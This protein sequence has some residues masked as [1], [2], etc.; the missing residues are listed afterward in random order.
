MRNL[1]GLTPILAACLALTTK[2]AA[3]QSQYGERYTE[4][5]EQSEPIVVTGIRIQDYRDRLRNCLARNCPPNEDIDATLALAEA[6][7]LSGEYGD[8]RAATRASIRRNR[9]QAQRYPEPVSD[10]YRAHSRLSR[11][12]G[13]DRE[14]LV[15]VNGIL[16]ALQQG[17]PD[18]DHRHFTARFEIAEIQLLSG[19]FSEAQ[20]SLDSL[21]RRARSVGREDVAVMAEL[22]SLLYADIA[23]PG[24]TAR[25][26]LIELS[27][28]VDPARR[29]E[30]L[31]AKSVLARIY[32]ANGDHE[33]ANALLAEIGRGT[34]A[35]RR[36]I[37]AP[38]YQLIGSN[39]EGD[40]TIRWAEN[41]QDKW[42]DVGFWVLP[43]GRVS[44]LE[45][46]RSGRETVWTRPLLESIRGRLY[47]TAEE[48]TY[49]LERYT[50]T[51]RREQPTGTRL[52]QQMADMAR[53]EYLDL[54]TNAPGAP[55][56]AQ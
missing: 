24:G 38:R 14:A 42:I 21:A 13:F 25:A 5:T 6:L 10:L 53:V 40:V 2:P 54:T 28:Q 22:R 8:A 27:R 46:L 32:R 3:A 36:L 34:S 45:I 18:E 17:I 41:F 1:S 33:R 29:R 52:Q 51:A 47:S 19:Y 16:D 43:D 30:A 7:L 55:P 35:R 31:G 50:L 26:R 56:P 4:P 23:A 12:L 9:D 49:R 37:H 44:D 48:P 15:S 11:S 39:G 20:R